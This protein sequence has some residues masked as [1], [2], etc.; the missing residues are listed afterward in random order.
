L[1]NGQTGVNLRADPIRGGA[2]IAVQSI[3]VRFNDLSER[4]LLNTE[5]VVDTA[6]NKLATSG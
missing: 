1:E 5:S 4:C 3:L 2:A 6:P